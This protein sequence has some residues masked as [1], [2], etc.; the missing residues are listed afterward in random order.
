QG[1]KR[2]NIK[3][4][5]G[6][7]ASTRVARSFEE[8]WGKG[9]RDRARQGCRARAPKEGFTARL[10]GLYPTPTW[11]HA[12]LP[13]LEGKGYVATYPHH[14]FYPLPAGGVS[15]RFCGSGPQDH[16]AKHRVQGV[17]RS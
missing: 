5:M 12:K 13:T 14:R 17:R 1:M 11:D 3:I 8:G 6:R 4:Q 15:Q 9:L 2:S 16:C 10:A 7:V